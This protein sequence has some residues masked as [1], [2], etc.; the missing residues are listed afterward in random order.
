MGLTHYQGERLGARANIAH[1]A[2]S[3]SQKTTSSSSFIFRRLVTRESCKEDNSC[4]QSGGTSLVIPIIVAIMYAPN[5]AFIFEN[6]VGRLDRI[7]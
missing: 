4:E 1:D 3:I 7:C 6:L 5:R 2:S